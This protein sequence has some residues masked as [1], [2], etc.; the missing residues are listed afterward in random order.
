MTHSIWWREKPH[1]FRPGTVALREIRKYQSSVGKTVP[2]LRYESQALSAF[3]HFHLCSPYKVQFSSNYFKWFFYHF[4]EEATEDYLVQFFEELNLSAIHD[5]R[6]TVM[7]KDITLIE[8]SRKKN[9][10]L[11]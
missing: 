8:Q 11:N 7:P 3:R 5:R 4:Y 9:L 10:S 2:G 1:R 6:V